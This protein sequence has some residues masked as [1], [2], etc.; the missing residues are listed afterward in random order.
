V[1]DKDRNSWADVEMYSYP[2]PVCTMPQALAP[3]TPATTGQ[4]IVVDDMLVSVDTDMSITF[5]E[6][7][8]GT[9]LFGPWYCTAKSG[10]IQITLRGKKKLA[11]ANKKVMIRT[12]VAGNVTC[13]L[14][15][16]SET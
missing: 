10:P 2:L 3:R 14:S 4:K 1:L 5:K 8:S 9:V 7:T 6:E 12:S 16:H 15:Y 13:Q 11:T